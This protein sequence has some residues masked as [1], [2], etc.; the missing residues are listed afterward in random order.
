[1]YCT[2][3]YCSVLYFV[4]LYRIV[5]HCIALYC[6]DMYCP[7]RRRAASPPPR[8]ARESGL[9]VALASGFAGFEGSLVDFRAVEVWVAKWSQMPQHKR[10]LILKWNQKWFQNRPQERCPIGLSNRVSLLGS[11]SLHWAMLLPYSTRKSGQLGP[12]DKTKMEKKSIQKSIKDLMG[13]DI[14]FCKDFDRF[15]NEN[16]IKLAPKSDQKSMSTSKG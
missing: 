5:L 14:G 2:L 13:F 1:M 12:Q 4:V 15:W 7:K 3:L 11:V 16:G 6:I 8:F 10:N 9:P